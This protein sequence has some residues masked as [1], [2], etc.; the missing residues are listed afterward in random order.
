MKKKQRLRFLGLGLD[1]LLWK[2]LNEYL[3]FVFANEEIELAFA[4]VKYKWSKFKSNALESMVSFQPDF[5]FTCASIFKSVEDMD[6]FFQSYQPTDLID[7]PCLILIERKPLRFIKQYCQSHPFPEFQFRQYPKLRIDNPRLFSS[8]TGNETFIEIKPLPELFFKQKRD[9]FL[10]REKLVGFAAW[11][12][13]SH[14]IWKNERYTPAE[15]SKHFSTIYQS[16]KPTKKSR[17]ILLDCGRAFIF[18]GF[19]LRDIS[20]IETDYFPVEHLIGF[21]QIKANAAD[22]NALLCKVLEIS[23]YRC[24]LRFNEQYFSDQGAFKS[25]VPVTIS[26]DNMLVCQL[27]QQ[28][29]SKDGYQR[30][31]IADQ[32]N[33]SADR[34]LISVRSKAVEETPF[35]YSILFDAETDTIEGEETIDPLSDIEMEDLSDQLQLQKS[36]N[37]LQQR[38]VKLSDQKKALTNAKEEDDKQRYMD[39]ISNTKMETIR[40]LL[41][42]SEIWDEHSCDVSVARSENVLILHD[43]QEQAEL[44]DQQLKNNNRKTFQAITQSIVDLESLVRF[45][46]GPLEPFLHDGVIICC[47]S[48]KALLLRRFHQFE[49]Q[50]S[51]KNYPPLTDAIENLN[52]E[53]KKCES[54]YQRL[55]ILEIASALYTLYKEHADRLFTAIVNYSKTLERNRFTLQHRR[56]IGIICDDQEDGECIQKAI[57]IHLNH[58]ESPEYTLICPELNTISEEAGSCAVVDDQ[59]SSERSTSVDQDQGDLLEYNAEQ[60]S[61]FFRS[62]A[63]R[64]GFLE[65]DILFIAGDPQ[66]YQ[67]LIEFLRQEGSRFINT[68]IVMLATG[69][70]DYQRMHELSQQGVR[71]LY[72]DHLRR[73]NP[74][75]LSQTFK[76]LLSSF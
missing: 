69:V 59:N 43:D 64:M 34:F 21:K 25:H 24:S 74:E 42:I 37:R 58:A 39:M 61:S 52:A 68:P 13:L 66:V 30:T 62:I 11:E 27:F 10:D 22:L 23:K 8:D 72:Q 48:T 3:T 51:Q 15:F 47:M 6:A 76:L 29:L 19:N 46:V 2:R 63:S 73:S 45:N 7:T 70:F 26:S 38:L 18:S 53:I 40:N 36:K 44:I 16:R 54:R 14:L 49:Y 9:I 57:D 28:I 50:I 5:I 4:F 1:Y 20:R 35:T 56:H 31:L 67:L 32:A 65:F 17:G 71:V 33:D 41:E 75:A 12:E 55:K 60:L